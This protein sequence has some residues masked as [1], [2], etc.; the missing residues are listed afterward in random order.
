M[1]SG[2]PKKQRKK[3]FTGKLHKKKKS[4]HA[5]LGNALRKEY[6]KKSAMVRAEDKVK[7]LRGKFRGKEGKVTKALH[8]KGTVFIEKITRKKSDGTEIQVPIKASN[9]MVTQLFLDDE[10]RLKR[11]GRKG[12]GKK[13]EKGKE[14]K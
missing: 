7:V 6:G 11:A 5:M 10:R 4:L 8:K 13:A 14:G 12:K 9:L 2:K 3:A 1:E